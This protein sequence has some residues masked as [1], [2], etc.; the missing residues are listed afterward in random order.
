MASVKF[1]SAKVKG[2]PFDYSVTVSFIH[3]CTS[4]G[5]EAVFSME[6]KSAIVSMEDVNF[7]RLAYPDWLE[8]NDYYKIAVREIAYDPA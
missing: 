6:H 4:E 8:D 1:H 5:I 2:N 3:A 7:I